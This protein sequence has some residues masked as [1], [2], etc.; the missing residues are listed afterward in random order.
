MRK[1][2][3]EP[4]KIAVVIGIL[5]L[6]VSCGAFIVTALLSKKD[7]DVPSDATNNPSFSLD[8]STEDMESSGENFT[9]PSGEDG[10]TVH[11]PTL[12]KDDETVTFWEDDTTP[13][14]FTMPEEGPLPT[15]PSNE[16][17]EPSGE[18]FTEPTEPPTTKPAEKP[19]SP[20]KPTEPSTTKPSVNPTE[21]PTTA[22]SKDPEKAFKDAGGKYEVKSDGTVKITDGGNA[23][24]DLVI[25]SKIDGKTVSEISNEAYSN[26]D[27]ITSITVDCE[28]VSHSC[29]ELCDKVR[30]VTI[31]PNVKV[32]EPYAF[33]N[34]PN[35]TSVAIQSTHIKDM[36]SMIFNG[37]RKLTS[38]T[39][40]ASVTRI[41]I[42]FI[43][44]A[45]EWYAENMSSR[46]ELV[47]AFTI[48]T[49]AKPGTVE[50][51]DESGWESMGLEY[52]Y[53]EPWTYTDSY[54]GETRYVYEMGTD[55]EAAMN[56]YF[57]R[58]NVTVVY[59]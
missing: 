27:N 56:S 59:K 30:S 43:P 16:E 29:F 23:K 26:N 8:N 11:R 5:V 53:G 58:G 20:T 49:Y 28:I 6:V 40:P 47:P 1:L 41:S 36:K 10:T 44:L 32:I 24:G 50:M 18:G 13:E 14:E 9:E 55:I 3:D 54:W 42:S 52:V 4:A 38:I 33:S 51:Y 45:G 15:R 2:K 46:E 34:L 31:G 25:P 37:C 39:L 35:L 21:P 17:T 19:T 48:Y 57:G 12:P 7:K 22:P